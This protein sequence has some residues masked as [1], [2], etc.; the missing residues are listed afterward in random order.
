MKTKVPA[1]LLL[2]LTCLGA[3]LFAN[4]KPQPPAAAVERIAALEA[5]NKSFKAYDALLYEL[6]GS[7]RKDPL[8]PGDLDAKGRGDNPIRS[9]QINPLSF[10]LRSLQR[11][12]QAP[13]AKS[14]FLQ[15]VIEFA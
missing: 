7:K 9:L 8:K 14:K 13:H 5:D 2:A 11:P 4:E 12:S 3:F 15:R 10:P 6:V 1:L